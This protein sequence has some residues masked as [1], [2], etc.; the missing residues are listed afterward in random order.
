MVWVLDYMNKKILAI[1]SI[2]ACCIILLAGLSPVVGYQRIK[3]SDA[4]DSPLFQVR[5][6]RAI[7]HGVDSLSC[8]YVGKGDLWSFPTRNSNLILI[9]KTINRFCQMDDI[10]FSRLTQLII[11]HAY[12]D[13]RIDKDNIEEVITTLELL[14]TNPEMVKNYIDDS[15][16]TVVFCVKTSDGPWVPGCIFWRI[17]DFIVV[18][19]LDFLALVSALSSCGYPTQRCCEY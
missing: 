11:N 13:V 10:A 17:F 9:Q 6:N 2:T 19:I 3:T 7:Q 18:S 15:R 8:E 1:G 4:T 14:R 12:Q 16:Y 5:T